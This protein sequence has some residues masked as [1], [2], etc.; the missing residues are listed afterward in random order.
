MGCWAA[1]W[2]CKPIWSNLSASPPPPSL[3]FVWRLISCFPHSKQQHFCFF[4]IKRMTVPKSVL[5]GNLPVMEQD[6]VISHVVISCYIWS[7]WVKK[8]R[9]MWG[10]SCSIVA[11]HNHWSYPVI[12]SSECLCVTPEVMFCARVHQT[13]K[14]LDF[15]HETERPILTLCLTLCLDPGV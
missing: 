9:K 1:H 5:L 13:A 11:F 2:P 7:A 12:W 8:G 10:L 6:F 14:D 3:L 15:C 4:L